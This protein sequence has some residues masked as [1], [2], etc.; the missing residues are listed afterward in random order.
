MMS[1]LSGA[2]GIR[3][4]ALAVSAFALLSTASTF[5]HAETLVA[6]G[7]AA[8]RVEA[9]NATL[10]EVLTVLR[11]S[12]GLKFQISTDLNR[13]VSG[14]YNGSLR[15]VITKLLYGYD[16]FVRKLGDDLE[17]V[18]LGFSAA[19]T[20]APTPELAGSSRRPALRR[21]F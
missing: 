7:P 11:S 9:Q 18:V 15:E 12:F 17:V 20:T 2:I 1:L 10:Q 19:A 6:G 21:D 14:T 3:N 8:L 16:F 5:T 4:A 13:S